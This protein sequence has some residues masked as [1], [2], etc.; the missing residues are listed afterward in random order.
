MVPEVEEVGSKAHL[1]PLSN[2]EVLQER[3]IPVLLER[4]V[5]SITP[6][7]P[8]PVVQKFRSPGPKVAVAMDPPAQPV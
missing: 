4:P 2:L 3:H 5:I 6:R 8:N 1:L 7:S